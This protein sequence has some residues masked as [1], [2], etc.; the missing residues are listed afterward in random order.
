MRVAIRISGLACAILAGAS[1]CAAGTISGT[2]KGPDGAAFEGAFVGAQNSK[3]RITVSALSDK[4]GHYQIQNLPDGDYELRIRAVGY[5][6]DPVSSLAVSSGKN[7]TSDF[8]LQKSVVR[9]NDL[10]MYQGEQLLP[11]GKGR[12]ELFRTCFACHGFESR[13]ASVTRDES[14]WRDRVNFMVTA[15]HFFVGGVGRFSDQD[16]ENVVS[17]LTSTFGPDSTKPK[18]P[19][20]LPK[21]A[22]LKQNFPD[23]ANNIV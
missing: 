4:Q 2:V 13:M 8:A 19:A 7:G 15:M 16:Q 23:K 5:K 14:G 20:D 18:S 12:A 6:A 10:S 9:W 3:T 17:Y 21:Y 11:D 22:E 1:I